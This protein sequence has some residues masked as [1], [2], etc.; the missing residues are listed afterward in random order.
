MCEPGFQLCCLLFRVEYIDGSPAISEYP[1]IADQPLDKVFFRLQFSRLG[2][3][4]N[5]S[6]QTR[7][8][9]LQRG[10]VSICSVFLSTNKTGSSVSPLRRWSR[11]RSNSV[12]ELGWM[13]GSFAELLRC[14]HHLRL[15]GP[16]RLSPP[17]VS[18]C[19][20]YRR[21]PHC[22]PRPVFYPDFSWPYPASIRILLPPTSPHLADQLRCVR[23]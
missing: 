10:A 18:P 11:R 23:S 1:V 14:H 20:C 7:S 22:P 9:V 16:V 19:Q 15:E 13:D 5:V 17:L 3:R 6:P 21:Y 8:N 2:H 12:Y 4:L